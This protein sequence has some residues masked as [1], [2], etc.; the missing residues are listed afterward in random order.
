[1]VKNDLT[2]MAHS[3]EGRFPY[4]DRLLLE[5]AQTIPPRLRI[6]GLRRRYM[7]KQAMKRLMPRAIQQRGNF[8]LEMPHS[9]W[10]A[11]EMRD[12]A[13]SW[14]T[15]ER[16]AALGFVDPDVA[17]GLWQAHLERKVDHGRGLWSLLNLVV[18]HAQ[19]VG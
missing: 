7:Q 15:R 13:E 9:T 12:F 3:I 14:L 11:T 5:F 2:F 8:G 4:M 18:W 1:M 16:I 19:F 17:L 6:K 10:F